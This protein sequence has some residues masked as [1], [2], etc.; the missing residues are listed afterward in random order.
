LIP[1]SDE[2]KLG[3][4]GKLISN[5]NVYRVKTGCKEKTEKL[6]KMTHPKSVPSPFERA[7]SEIL[8][9]SIAETLLQFE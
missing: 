9:F 8:V 4:I 5:S 2:D 1:K 3:G 7:A 6:D